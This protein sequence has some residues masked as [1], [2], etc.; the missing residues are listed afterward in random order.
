MSLQD[1]GREMIM[2]N[3]PK[4]SSPERRAYLV[5]LFTKYGNQCLQG[6]HA[7]PIPEHYLHIDTKLVYVPYAKTVPCVNSQGLP[8]RDSNGNPFYITVYPLRKVIER[9]PKIDRLYDFKTE[10]IIKDWI[11]D[12]REQSLEDWKA[13]QK[14]LHRTNDRILPLRGQFSGVARD[15]FHDNQPLYYLE[16][17]GISG[18]T[19]KP[20]A[21][22][23]LASSYIRLH[24]DLEDVLKPMSKSK[25]RKAIRY[26]KIPSNITNRIQV[27][28]WQAVKHYL[29]S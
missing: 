10:S 18:L 15:I 20:F 12:T 22:L 6:H 28:C 9:I 2:S 8:L 7:C 3:Y 11:A 19:F 24:V 25:K 4:W 14:A 17:M 13:E 23:R 21:K 5:K 26:G 1:K 27:L 16:A 29:N